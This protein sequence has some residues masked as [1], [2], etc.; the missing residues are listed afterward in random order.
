VTGFVDG[1]GSF[2][3]SR[4][5]NQIALYFAVKLT[6]SERPL[7]EDIQAF[8]GGIGTI[9]T[10]AARAPTDRAG[11]TKTAAYYR[12]TR[13]DELMTVVDHFDHYPLRSSKRNIYE[14]WRTMVLVK[15][16]FRRPDRAL[17]DELADRITE[18]C[19][20]KQSWR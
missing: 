3:Y 13:R 10:A 8:L 12:V 19:V 1:E 11:A 6:N 18:L 16:Q 4:S 15:Q 5:S 14:L 20:R 7:L 2:T 9:Y 17:L